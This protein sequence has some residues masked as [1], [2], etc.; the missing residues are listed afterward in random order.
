ML[1]KFKFDP[2]LAFALF[3]VFTT[4][5]ILY[6]SLNNIHKVQYRAGLESGCLEAKR[7]Y[8]ECRDLVRIYDQGRLPE[9][10]ARLEWQLEQLQHKL[11]YMESPEGRANPQGWVE[12]PEP[13]FSHLNKPFWK[14]W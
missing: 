9:H 5:T 2:L 7:P 4:G 3:V 10:K 14:F 11:A 8:S 13:D 1:K 6:T 12:T